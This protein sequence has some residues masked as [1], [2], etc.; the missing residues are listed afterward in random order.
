M[1]YA[2]TGDQKVLQRLNYM[3]GELKKCQDK[4]GS[5]YVAGIPGGKAMWEDVAKGK[6][7]AGSSP[8]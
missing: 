2:A 4:D 7:D 6:I 3:I 1:M 5:G 8:Q